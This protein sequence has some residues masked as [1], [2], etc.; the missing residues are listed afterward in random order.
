MAGFTDTLQGGG[1]ARA[2]RAL[3]QFERDP[4][5]LDRERVRFDD[6]LSVYASD[7]SG[8]T[9]RSQSPDG[10]SEEQ[11]LQQERRNKLAEKR[12]ASEPHKQFAAQVEEE[13]RRIWNSDPS[14]K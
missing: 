6:P 9:T 3:L 10:P 13:R 11:Q 4:Q 1:L 2:Q 5:R 12:Q 14:T 8:T 7:R